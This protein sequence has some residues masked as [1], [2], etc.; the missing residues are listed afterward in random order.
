VSNLLLLSGRA[1]SISSNHETQSSLFQHAVCREVV[2]VPVVAVAALALAVAAL[3]LVAVALAPAVVDPDLAVVLALGVALA[4]AVVG[5][6][7]L[8][9]GDVPA[10]KADGPRH[11]PLYREPF[12]RRRLHTLSPTRPPVHRAVP[13]EAQKPTLT[14][15]HL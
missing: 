11:A 14:T 6:A 7:V 13:R 10:P 15:L 5:P 9:A 2:A 4:P 12:R 3:V 1:L 8:A